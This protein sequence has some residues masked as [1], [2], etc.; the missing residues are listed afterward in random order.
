MLRTPR[1]AYL[2]PLQRRISH[3]QRRALPINHPISR[4]YPRIL[5]IRR[6]CPLLSAGL[7]IRVRRSD[8]TSPLTLRILN[9][10]RLL[11]LIDLLPPRT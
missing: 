11:S 10:Q 1:F 6:R 8:R 7:T 9:M 5:H 3:I 2:L 4:L